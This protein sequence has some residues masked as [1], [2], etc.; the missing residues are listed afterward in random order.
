M[1]D[2]ATYPRPQNADIGPH[3][4]RRLDL[5][6]LLRIV[7]AAFIASGCISIIEPS[8]YD[9][10]S[11]LAIAVW[12]LGGFRL[13]VVLMPMIFL[14]VIYT[15]AGFVALMPH[16]NEHDS[17]LFQFQSLYLIV[18]VVFFAMFFSEKT[19]DRIDLCLKAFTFGCVA[20]SLLG[21]LGYLGLFG[22][23][24]YTVMYEG[25]VSGT[26]KDP[27]VFGSYLVMALVYLTHGLITG[28]TRRPFLVIVS[29]GI[30]ALGIFLS[31]SRGSWG[32]A[33]IALVT[34]FIVTFFTAEDAPTR[35]RMLLWAAAAITIAILGII[36]I[37]SFDTTRE[38]FLQRATVTQD[39]DEGLTGRFGNQ[40]RSLPMLLELPNGFGPLR[41]RLFFF[42]EPHN[43]YIN[44]FASYGWVGG[45]TW[46]IL[47]ASTC[48]IGFRLTFM[49]SPYR[50]LAHVCW[51]PLFAMLLQGF[52]IDIDHWR[53]VFLGFGMIWGMEAAR[54]R[55]QWQQRHIAREAPLPASAR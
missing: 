20:S 13:N 31:F 49:K 7:F 41:F 37:L 5:E 25:R 33:V 45:F 16:W 28:R 17:W 40:L 15:V 2:T 22:L 52:Q 32:A 11:L 9:F 46:L 10:L 55:W 14:W 3:T 36:V 18:T 29:T 34:M 12:A 4:R 21:I 30:V 50:D 1:S 53:W 8:P 35:R 19:H 43:S 27:N 44:A 23:A 48:F 24:D 47:V 26:F 38:L 39:Y 6:P 54:I 42:L 51:P